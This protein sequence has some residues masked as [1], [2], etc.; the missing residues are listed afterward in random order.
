MRGRKPILKVKKFR[1]SDFRNAGQSINS[2]I[3]SNSG[4]REFKSDYYDNKAN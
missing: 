4:M 1:H 2:D 3:I